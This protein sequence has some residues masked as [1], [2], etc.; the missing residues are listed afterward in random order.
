MATSAYNVSISRKLTSLKDLLCF[1]S[2]DKAGIIVGF[3][4]LV[5][6]KVLLFGLLVATALGKKLANLIKKKEKNVI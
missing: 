1:N 5:F 3:I 2:I 4:H 6:G